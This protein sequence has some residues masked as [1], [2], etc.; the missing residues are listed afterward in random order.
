VTPAASCPIAGS[1]N[2]HPAVPLA[3]SSEPTPTGIGRLTRDLA[4]GNEA[5]FREF[6]A[7][8]F[9]RLYHFLLVVTRGETHAAQDALQETLLRVARYAR[10]FD[11]EEIFWSWLK[12][13]ARSVAR[14]GSRKERRYLARL[15]D[16]ALGRSSLFAAES[17]AAPDHLRALLLETLADLSLA[18]RALIEG[19]YFAGETVAELAAQTGLTEK[20]VESRLGRLR[21]QLGE[22]VRKKLRRP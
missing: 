15:R 17:P 18:D 10:R 9:D 2:G 20:A 22:N 14:D 8:Y 5:A 21:N 13:V 11:E 7:L 1:L 4:Q 19:K 6:H 3:E 12:A 16:F